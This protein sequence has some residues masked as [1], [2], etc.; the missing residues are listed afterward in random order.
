MAEAGNWTC[1]TASV[2]I[3]VLDEPG[4]ASCANVRATPPPSSGRARR[5]ANERS[6]GRYMGK[7]LNLDRSVERHPTGSGDEVFG[8]EYMGISR[9][10]WPTW[11]APYPAREGEPTER[12]CGNVSN[13]RHRLTNVAGVS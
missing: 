12:P 2:G 8:C 10:A 11:H 13:G 7:P 3:S 4:V 9:R 6:R 1:A 5:R